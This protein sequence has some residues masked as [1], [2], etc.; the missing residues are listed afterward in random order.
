MLLLGSPKDL[1][2][3]VERYEEGHSLLG[4]GWERENLAQ[5]GDILVCL[6]FSPLHLLSS[7]CVLDSGK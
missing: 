2:Q 7:Y 3:M 5:C 1:P 6:K 4:E